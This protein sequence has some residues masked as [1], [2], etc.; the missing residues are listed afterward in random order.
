MLSPVDETFV[1]FVSSDFPQECIVS[2]TQPNH[3]GGAKY[4]P[5]GTRAARRRT[6]I[7]FL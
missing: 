3:I 7:R 5:N 2:S 1:T 4:A 6:R